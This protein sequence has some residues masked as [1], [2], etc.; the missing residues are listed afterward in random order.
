MRV[1]FVSLFCSVLFGAACGHGNT[2]DNKKTGN[3]VA[4]DPGTVVDTS[5]STCHDDTGS[6]YICR[7]GSGYC[8]VCT[9]TSFDDGCTP[10]NNGIQSY[11]VHSCSDC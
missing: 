10:N 6:A 1:L 7:N 5:A 9:G 11:C 3:G 4:C 2:C 8:V